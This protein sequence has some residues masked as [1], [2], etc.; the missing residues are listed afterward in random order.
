MVLTRAAK[1]RTIMLGLTADVS[2]AHRRCRVRPAEW[3]WQLCRPSQYSVW[4][5]TDHLVIDGA[6][7]F[8]GLLVCGRLRLLGSRGASSSEPCSGDGSNGDGR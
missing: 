5:N 1:M 3:K 8:L 2:K 6:E 4:A 7:R